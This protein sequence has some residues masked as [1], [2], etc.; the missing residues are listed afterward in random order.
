MKDNVRELLLADQGIEVHYDYYKDKKG[1]ERIKIEHHKAQK[2][3]HEKKQ[4]LL[5]QQ[6]L[7]ESIIDKWV[8]KEINNLDGKLGE[9]IK[10]NKTK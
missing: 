7:N 9:Y 3:I 6:K 1:Q 8:Q 5:A 10:V 2:L 4:L